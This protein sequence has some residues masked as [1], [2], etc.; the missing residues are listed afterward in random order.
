MQHFQFQEILVKQG[1]KSFVE[2][3]GV[4]YLELV[5]A[6]NV[7]T[8]LKDGEIHSRVKGIDIDYGFSTN[9]KKVIRGLEG[10]DKVAFYKE[11]F[12]VP[13]NANN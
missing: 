3:H 11:C 5:R 4:H 10:F 13:P 12:R 8:R 9:G 6:F 1:V 2:M 7:N